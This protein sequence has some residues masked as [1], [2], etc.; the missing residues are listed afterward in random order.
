MQYCEITA[1]NCTGADE[2]F[3]DE[4]TCLTACEAYAEDE[5][6]DCT[7]PNDCAD[8]DT[9]VECRIYHGDAASGNPGLHC[10][11]ASPGGDGTCG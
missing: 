8:A 3:A 4:P 2:L 6:L 9:G 10:G 5:T 11:H 7:D 1:A